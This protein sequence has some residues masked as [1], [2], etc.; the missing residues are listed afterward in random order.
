MAWARGWSR[1]S[2]A[3]HRR[4]AAAV[5]RRDR[6]VCQLRLDGCQ[7]RAS[8]ADHVTAVAEGG[9]PLDVANGQAVCASCHGRKTREEAARGRARRSRLRPV[10]PHPGA[11]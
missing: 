4:W 9:E 6:F 1:T 8:A 10:P 3:E 7:R 2:S 5:L 11:V